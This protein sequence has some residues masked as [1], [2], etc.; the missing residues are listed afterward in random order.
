[1]AY[2]PTRQAQTRLSVPNTPGV[3]GMINQAK[4][5]EQVA[6]TLGSISQNLMSQTYEAEENADVANAILEASKIVKPDGTINPDMAD[7]A[8]KVWS[9][10]G[11]NTYMRSINQTMSTWSDGQLSSLKDQYILQDPTG[12]NTEAR[13]AYDQSVEELRSSLDAYPV[14]QANFVHDDM[15][16]SIEYRPLNIIVQI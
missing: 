1:M 7:A 12:T 10:K 9:S 5:S 3:A 15:V 6:R 2:K 13:S 14:A 11:M 16:F 4:A 8:S